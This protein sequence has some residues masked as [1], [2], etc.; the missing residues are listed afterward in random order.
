MGIVSKNYAKGLHQKSPNIIPIL[1]LYRGPVQHCVTVSRVLLVF[2]KWFASRKFLLVFFLNFGWFLIL[3][4]GTLRIFHDDLLN[5]TLERCRL[6]TALTLS[7]LSD[8]LY[9]WTTLTN[10]YTSASV[11]MIWHALATIV[12]IFLKLH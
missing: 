2:S 12:V 5:G 1:S 11:L 3:L 9:T 8:S 4:S 7:V 6:L 10:N